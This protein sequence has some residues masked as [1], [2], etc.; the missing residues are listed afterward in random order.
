MRTEK[1]VVIAMILALITG[2]A[3]TDL[4]NPTKNRAFIEGQQLIAEGQFDAGL[5][6]LE[7]AASEEPDNTEIRLVLNRQQEAI[8]AQLLYEADNLRLSGELDAAEQKYDYILYLFPHSERTKE[9]IEALNLER[10]HIASIDYAKELLV[11]NDV[12]GAEAAARAVLLENPMQSHARQLIKEISTSIAR[13]DNPGLTLKTA[14][15]KPFTIEFRDTELK[16]VFEIMAKTAGINF[17]FDK[18]IRQETK[19]SIFVR[20]NN[21]EDVLNLI[22][23]T[24][25]LAY[26]ALNENSLLIYPNTP[27]KQKEYQ[28]L[29]VRS[30][31][32]AYTDVKQMVA[33]VRGLVK[34]KDI[35]VNEQLNLFVMRDTPEA[36]RMVE[37]LVSLND[38][39]EPE[40]MLEVQVLE[41]QRAIDTE[42][43]PNLPQSATYSFVPGAGAIGVTLDQ[44][45]APGLKN[46]TINNQVSIDFQKNLAQ[47]DL[48][49]NPRI[50]VKNREQAKI[51]IG[52]RVPIITSNVTGT[53]ATVSQSVNYIDVGLKFDIEPIISM[54]N[55]VAIKLLLEVST[56]VSFVDSGTS[57]IPQVGTRTAETLLSLKDGETEVLAGLIQDEDTKNFKGIAG[58]IDLPILNRL[59]TN[60]TRNRKKT[61]IVMLITPRILRNTKQPTNAESEFHFGTS[62]MPGKLPVTI[63]KTAPESLAIATAGSGR[64]G[65]SSAL[66]RA[67][68]NFSPSNESQETPNPFART[69]DASPMISLQAPPRVALDKEFTVRVGLIGAQPS[70][71][72]EM[73]LSYDTDMLQALDDG[74]NSGRREIKLGKDG[75]GK[76][77]QI[78]F[79]VITAN[80]GTAE[81]SVQNI[82]SEDKETSESVEVTEPR[83]ASIIIQ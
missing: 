11:R 46:F 58:L 15:K 57:Q 43:G 21:I 35:Y 61:E 7:Q 27:A 36:I 44:I 48:L 29:V 19:I 65:G 6:L 80:P 24:N 38:L 28:E 50:R 75:T 34:A 67:A 68:G 64:G 25:Q 20:D 60:Q 23:M 37:R 56:I 77:E 40:L 63:G 14:F 26:K 1:Y 78:R 16:S 66:S 59:F 51:L 69:A 79:K 13:T 70:V 30:F 71:T 49:A 52:E 3:A 33:M 42:I 45:S 62:N 10:H 47:G 17:V 32:V 5:Q 8:L 31:H 81:I 73:E 22:L 18:D 39:P 41:I 55:E 9:G 12:K 74:D 54:N 83:T 4:A 82:I 72:S 53:A 2:C 76:T